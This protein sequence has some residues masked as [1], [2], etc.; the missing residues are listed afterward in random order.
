MNCLIVVMQVKGL[1]RNEAAIEKNMQLTIYHIMQEQMN[2]I[3]KYAKATQVQ[4]KVVQQQQ[5]NLQVLVA[6]N[7]VGFD[8][9][10]TPTGLGLRNI[11]HRSQIFK[12]T[13]TLQTAPGAGCKLFTNFPIS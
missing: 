13:M 12:G 2:N 10:K 7:G 8:A 6:D 3:V 4:I 1:R 5:Q 11:E 9:G